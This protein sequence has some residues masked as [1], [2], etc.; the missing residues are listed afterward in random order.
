MLRAYV[1]GRIGRRGSSFEALPK[2]R[3]PF[4]TLHGVCRK[5]LAKAIEVVD[6]DHFGLIISG[7]R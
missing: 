5:V 6:D 1:R 3:Y 7:R 2:M 4:E